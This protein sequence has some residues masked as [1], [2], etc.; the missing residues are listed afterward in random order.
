MSK[1][2]KIEVASR[3]VIGLLSWWCRIRARTVSRL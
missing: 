3:V 2:R 1:S